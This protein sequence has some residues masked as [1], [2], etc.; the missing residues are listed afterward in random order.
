MFRDTIDVVFAHV[1]DLLE[2]EDAEFVEGL[3]DR[4][5][6]ALDALEVIAQSRR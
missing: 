1:G 5:P 6:D 3:L 4:G 2:A